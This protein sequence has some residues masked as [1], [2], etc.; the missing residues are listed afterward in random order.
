MQFTFCSIDTQT[1]HG[2]LKLYSTQSA[3]HLMLNWNPNKGVCHIVA[4]PFTL[5]KYLFKAKEEWWKFE[6]FTMQKYTLQKSPLKETKI[7]QDII[8]L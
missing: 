7:H 1:K 4:L 3:I 6:Y 2:S 5:K 8:T